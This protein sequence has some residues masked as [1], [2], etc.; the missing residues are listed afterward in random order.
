MIYLWSCIVDVDPVGLSVGVHD[1]LYMPLVLS[2]AFVQT[3]QGLRAPCDGGQR[4]RVDP[5]EDWDSGLRPEPGHLLQLLLAGHG[6]QAQDGGVGV[7]ELVLLID[8]RNCPALVGKSQPLQFL[9]LV[10]DCPA[11][12]AAI[13]ALLFVGEGKQLT[14]V[15]KW[16]CICCECLENW[17]PR[18][19]PLVSFGQ[20]EPQISDVLTED[21]KAI[22]VSGRPCPPNL[23]NPGDKAKGQVQNDRVLLGV[24]GSE[25]E[26]VVGDCQRAPDRSCAG[27]GERADEGDVLIVGADLFSKEQRHLSQITKFPSFLFKTIRAFTSSLPSWWLTDTLGPDALGGA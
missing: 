14:I 7:A 19:S 22:V 9:S 27:R 16:K 3:N 13:A 5:G 25:V 2:T 17:P 24:V 12:G 11:V 4:L 21:L 1:I 18:M 10:V 20:G 6:G 26:P 23:V 15:G 8:L